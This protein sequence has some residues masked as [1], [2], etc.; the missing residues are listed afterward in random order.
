MLFRSQIDTSDFTRIQEE[1]QRAK[2]EERKRN[3]EN[4]E[5]LKALVN[6]NQQLVDYNRQLV[7]LNE[8]VLRKINIVSDAMENIIKNIGEGNR[9]IKELNDEQTKLLLELINILESK[10]NKG[11][12]GDFLKQFTGNVAAGLIIAYLQLKLGLS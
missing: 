9:S 8:N 1:I 4:N 6:Y 10:E 11:K 3:I 5:N 2:D 7:S 12:L